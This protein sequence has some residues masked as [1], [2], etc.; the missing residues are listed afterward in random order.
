M[1]GNYFS[2]FYSVKESANEIVLK[3]KWI[4]FPLYIIPLGI[5]GVFSVG[6]LEALGIFS[7]L[8]I[9]ALS[10]AYWGLCGVFNSV[11][12]TINQDFIRKR[13]F[14]FPWLTGVKVSTKN[15]RGAGITKHQKGEKRGGKVIAGSIST[16]GY[17]VK[18]SVEKTW[19]D[20]K[21]T[22]ISVGLQEF[23]TSGNDIDG[24]YFLRDSLNKFVVN[25]SQNAPIR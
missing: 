9:A 7:L 6:W 18:M 13:N 22:I 23:S 8:T 4:W 10:V 5:G 2:G 20:G 19:S 15:L 21:K 25:E 3:R 14:P 16:T 12:I 11:V 17:E 1:K 24:A